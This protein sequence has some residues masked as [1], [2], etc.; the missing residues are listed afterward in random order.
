MQITELSD[1]DMWKHI[2][3]ILLII[4][5][6]LSASASIQIDTSDVF[7]LTNVDIN[8]SV[9]N[10]YD[11]VDVGG[12]YIDFGKGIFT[13]T[14]TNPINLTIITWENSGNYSKVFNESSANPVTITTHIFSAGSFPINTV[15]QIN[16]D[17]I[18]HAYVPSDAVGALSW[19]YTGG[20]SPHLF[21]MTIAPSA[22]AYV[23]SGCQSVGDWGTIGF[24]LLAV[25]LIVI[26][27]SLAIGWLTGNQTEMIE[28]AKY[29]T[30]LIIVVIIGLIGVA[31]TS[32]IFDLL[33]C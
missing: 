2:L 11:Y 23:T 33:R 6:T 29:T 22:S 9:N 31:L 1:V 12:T 26:A 28:I 5:L 15:I 18:V 21:E 13:I 7:R 8:F 19:T 14:P 10:T 20:Y 24:E 17:G 25:L 3:S 16:R 32:P 4:S 27:G 30:V